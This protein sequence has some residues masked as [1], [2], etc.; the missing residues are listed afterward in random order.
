T[1]A[2]YAIADRSDEPGVRAVSCPRVI[3]QA[4]GHCALHFL[5]VTAGTMFKVEIGDIPLESLAQSQRRSQ[6]AH[7]EKQGG[8]FSSFKHSSDPSYYCVQC[9]I[10]LIICRSAEF[11]SVDWSAAGCFPS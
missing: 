4:V 3:Q 9:I 5:A 7:Q 8:E 2:R 1:L 10:T 11:P 6:K